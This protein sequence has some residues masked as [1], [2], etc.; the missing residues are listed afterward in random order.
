MAGAAGMMTSEMVRSIIGLRS[1]LAVGRD[2]RE[3]HYYSFAPAGARF[4]LRHVTHGLR[5]GLH[6]AAASRLGLSRGFSIFA[7]C[8]SS[9]FVSLRR[10]LLPPLRGWTAEV[11]GCRTKTWEASLAKLTG[12]DPKQ[13]SAARPKRPCDS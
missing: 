3:R 13:P 7:S 10:G 8:S 6:S 12:C 11:G 5:R 4:H 2:N 9:S 1:W